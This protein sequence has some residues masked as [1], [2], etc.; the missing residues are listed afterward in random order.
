MVKV[1][2]HQLCKA[3]LELYQDAPPAHWHGGIVGTLKTDLSHAK[4]TVNSSSQCIP[5]CEWT[6][7]KGSS[8][9][10]HPTW[11]SSCGCREGWRRGVIHCPAEWATVSWC[12]F[13]HCPVLSLG[14]AALSLH[15]LSSGYFVSSSVIIPP[16]P[17]LLCGECKDYSL[18]ALKFF[19]WCCGGFFLVG[20]F[21]CWLFGF[22]LF[23]FLVLFCFVLVFSPN[24]S[25]YSFWSNT[26]EPVQLS[27][28]EMQ[29]C[30][31]GFI[32]G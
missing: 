32:V 22:L 12:D 25:S 19:W 26:G 13:T 28:S 31:C 29:V 27:V 23:W 16:W 21:C 1:E 9:K 14:H 5:R 4:M 15:C 17:F 7:C 20:V 11:S 10:L 24:T 3:C 8:W 2:C 6:P 18:D 30:S